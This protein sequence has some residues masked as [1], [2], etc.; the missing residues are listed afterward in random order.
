MVL[1]ITVRGHCLYIVVMLTKSLPVTAVPEDPWIPPVWD[2]MVDHSCLSIHRRILPQTLLAKR[3]FSEE[4]LPCF[5]PFR[6]IPAL[7]RPRPVLSLMYGGMH[8]A[9]LHAVRNKV[10]TSRMGTGMVRDARHLTSSG[11]SSHPDHG[12]HDAASMHKLL[13]HPHIP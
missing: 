12:S 6:V 5:P 8:L 13:S 11:Y 3:M 1:L 2:D 9:V 10:R 7:C 4:S